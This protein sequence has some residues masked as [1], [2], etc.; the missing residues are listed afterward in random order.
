[1]RGFLVFVMALAAGASLATAAKRV[2]IAERIAAASAD[3]GDTKPA[4]H[5]LAQWLDNN[6]F[7]NHSNWMN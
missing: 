4:K 7:F 5:R 3:G 6:P 1:M 2:E